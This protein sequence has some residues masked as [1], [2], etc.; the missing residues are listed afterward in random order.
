MSDTPRSLR[1]LLAVAL[2]PL[3]L[4]LAFTA[5][6]YLAA[7]PSL[8]LFIGGVFVATLLAPPLVL[9]RDDALDRVMVAMSVVDGV[10]IVWLVAVFTT[11]TTFA[12]WLAAYVLLAAYVTALEGI[13]LAL[14]RVRFGDVASSAVTVT[15][16]LAWLTWPVWFSAWATASTVRVLVRVHPLFAL[17][18]LLHHLG[19]WG[20]GRLAYR[21]TNLGQD[22]P[23]HLP[24][25]VH[26]A[27]VLH[28]LLGGALL[29]L[30]C[31]R[32]RTG[33][34]VDVPDGHAR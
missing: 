6:C 8:G 13:T 4:S 25:S 33:P 18:G 30:A 31:R 9:W 27:I 3:L 17:N 2:I 19:V 1:S 22:V 34:S 14:R 16:A 10:A 24:N 29:L 26:R 21:L 32:R 28:M 7:G 23:Y 11:D 12:H 15:L 20:E 5:A